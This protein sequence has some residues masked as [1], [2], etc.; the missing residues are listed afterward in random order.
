MTGHDLAIRSFGAYWARAFRAGH[1]YAELAARFRAT[2]DPLWLADSRRNLLH[3][4]ALLL[5]MLALLIVS[6]PVAF[7]LMSCAALLVLRTAYRC[8]WKGAD[9]LTRIYY[10]VHSHFQQIPIM[11]GQLNYQRDVLLGRQRG[12][13]EYKTS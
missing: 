4:S 8:R 9:F 13:I 5:G 7:G 11:W 10:A 3:G 12:L 2:E 1:A 6:I